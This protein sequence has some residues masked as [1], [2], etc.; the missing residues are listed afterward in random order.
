MNKKVF[1]LDEYISKVNSLKI[2]KDPTSNNIKSHKFNDIC[3]SILRYFQDVV[4]E[5]E[6]KGTDITILERQKKAI[7]GEENEV[8]YFKSEIR[9]Y[10]IK[11]NLLGSEYPPHFRDI[12]DAIFHQNWGLDGIAPWKDISNSPSA[13][14]VGGKIF[15]MIDG[16]MQLQEQSM[17]K[18][19][20]EQLKK[21]LLLDTPIV[22]GNLPYYELYM[23]GGER[24][25]IYTGDLTKSGQDIMVFRKYLV[26]EYSF[27]E[28]A[29]RNTIPKE[30][31][32]LFQSLAK[33]GFNVLFAGAVGTGKTT[34]LTTW[35]SMEDPT[36]E[37]V[38][39]ET[40]PEIPMH[41][42][43]PTA[44]IMQLISDGKKL[45]E[46]VKNLMRSDADYLIMAESRDG[47]AL[48]LSVEMANKGTRRSKTTVHLTNID[49]ICYDIAQ[50]IVNDIGGN[51]DY[52]IMKVAKSFHYVIELI[53]LPN[54][55]QKRVKGIHE[56]RYDNKSFEIS[57][58]QIMKYSIETDSWTFFYDT[59]PKKEEI[60][61]EENY[62]AYQEFKNELRDLADKYP[63]SDDER[64]V[65]PFYSKMLQKS[66]S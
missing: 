30:S 35:Q 8:N 17:S 21:A 13:K 52:T 22:K 33:V 20:F 66:I 34:F 44:P 2:S 32:S 65:V 25:T 5:S 54:K 14:I 10:L 42:L 45:Q 41:K 29:E 23:T 59:D 53:K 49:D 47:F 28:L 40:D 7:V 58:R 26:E 46:I 62:E 11:N 36:L 16:K 56:I 1:Y 9:N 57:V 55:N 6:L 39:V 24:I 61:L 50:K 31:V 60:A 43:L 4:F 12:T 63:M 27:E 15:F 51:L 48:N 37:G 18:E 64:V 3:N 19:R 38:L